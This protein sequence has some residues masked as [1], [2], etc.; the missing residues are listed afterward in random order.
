MFRLLLLLTG[1]PGSRIVFLEV[2]LSHSFVSF[3]TL[4]SLYSLS[5]IVFLI[6]SLLV[7][8]LRELE[9]ISFVFCLLCICLRC[10]YFKTVFSLL[11]L[12]FFI[13]N[14]LI[15]PINQCSSQLTTP[16]TW[17]VQVSCCPIGRSFGLTPWY[18]EL[19]S[20]CFAR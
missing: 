20:L 12:L 17:F 9:V 2:F 18:L 4:F 15:Q 7:Y 3:S 19:E 16:F 11:S 6:F 5:V 13:N 8:F 1:R 14:Q 10:T